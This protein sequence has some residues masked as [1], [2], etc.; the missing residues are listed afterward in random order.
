VRVV[1]NATGFN[2]VLAP[3]IHRHPAPLF[4]IVDKPIIVHIIEYLQILGIR[5]FEIILNHLPEKIEE[6]LGEGQRWGIQITYHLVR[7]ADKPFAA[8]APAAHHWSEKTV[9]FGHA[10]ILPRLHAKVLEKQLHTRTRLFFHGTR[11][12]IGWGVIP[13]ETVRHLDRDW[14]YF[15]LPQK[16]PHSSKLPVSG[17][18]LSVQTLHDWQMSNHRM[19][20]EHSPKNS[21][22]ATARMIEPGIWVSRATVLHPSV[23]MK[24]PLFI[25]E[26]CQVMEGAQ[27]GPD[28]VIENHCIIDKRS[29]ILRSLICERSYVGE[30]LE[31]YRSI[32]DQHTLLNLTLG[33]AVN[34]S[35]DFILCNVAPPA[36]RLQATRLVE[37]VSAFLLL[38][39]L[40]PL[41]AAGSCCYGLKS[42]PKVRL[43]A[44]EESYHWSTFELVQFKK[45]PL[46]AIS[47]LPALINVVRG[48]LHFVGLRPRS[49]D[50][51]D[52]LQP[53]QR[54]FV[55]TG[56][57]GWIAVT[58]VEREVDAS[59][60]ESLYVTRQSFLEDLKLVWRYL[61]AGFR[62]RK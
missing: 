14:S 34:I 22:P 5:H 26:N 42:T 32:V 10:E 46:S 27:I 21:F 13:V 17:V 47:R 43:P 6:C 2:P 36:L 58:D 50:E 37:R 41:V 48:H 18:M 56:K 30:G 49:P 29:S 31:V 60:V 16:L 20:T 24:P 25:G 8:V 9:M 7:E 4:R 3:F 15:D 59:L 11:G 53:E 45:P 35:D 38:I 28:V 54:R 61:T 39:I 51:I 62:K 1:L 23:M 57:S 12:W 19:L 44:L 33:T 40:S 55:L 52:V